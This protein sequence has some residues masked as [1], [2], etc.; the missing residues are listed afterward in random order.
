MC[1]NQAL[2][3]DAIKLM[4]MMPT[5]L[6]VVYVVRAMVYYF[7]VFPLF[8]VQLNG[9]KTLDCLY[10]RNIVSSLYAVYNVF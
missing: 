4:H 3:V 2:D 7:E 10:G 6:P 8:Y 5:L 9:F 1:L